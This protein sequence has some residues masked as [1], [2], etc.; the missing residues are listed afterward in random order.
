MKKTIFTTTLALLTTLLMCSIAWAQGVQKAPR[1]V[2]RT[3]YPLVTH[4]LP[5]ESPLVTL[6]ESFEGATFPPAGWTKLSPDGGAGW[7]RQLNN[8]APIPGWQGGRITVPPGGGNAVAFCTWNT[9]GAS[10][11]NQ[12]L[13][14]PQLTNVLA[15]DSLKFWMRY[16]PNSFSDTVEVRIS[17]TTPTVGAF[18]ILVATLPFRSPSADTN[19]NQYRYRLSDYVP[20]G[21]NIYVAFRERVSD[22]LNDGASISLDLVQVTSD[23][24]VTFRVNMKVQMLQGDFQPG[25]GDLVYVRG[26]FNGWNPVD[27]LSDGDG[28]SIYTKTIAMAEGSI[29]Y[30]YYK[31]QARGS[32]DWENDPD[33]QYTV[34]AGPQ[35]TPLVFFNRD[36]IYTPPAV[37]VPV[38]FQV[39][40]RVKMLEG[41]FNPGGGDIVRVAGNI[42]DWG[43]SLDTLRDADNDSIYTKTL[44]LA[45]GR[46]VLYKFLKTNNGSLGW[47]DGNNRIHIVPVGGGPIP[48]VYFDNDSLVSVPVSANILYHTDMR[49]FEQLG[50]F[51]P[52]VDS[53]QMRGSPNGWGGASMEP[54]PLAPGTYFLVVP[55]SGFSFD[56]IPYKY[57]MKLDSATA[58]TRFP[59]WADNMDGYNYEHP[60]VRGDGNRVFTVPA[61]GQQTT[62][63]HWY[64]DINPNGLLLNNTDSVTVTLRVN[65]GPAKRYITP[66]NPATDTVRVIWG[67]DAIWA[68]VQ[69]LYQGSFPNL[70]MSQAPGGGD[71]VYQVSFLV[72]GKTHYNIQYSYRYTQPGGFSVDEGGGLGGQNPQRSRFI[73][74]LA[75]NSFPR[76]YTAP[77]D[78]WQKN[79]PMPA[80]AAPFPILASVEPDLGPGIPEGYKLGQNYPNPFNPATKI[81]YTI[82]EKSKVTLF[83]YNLLGQKVSEIVNQEQPAGAYIATF[84][85]ANLPTGVYFYRLEAGKFM[86]SR[87]MLLLK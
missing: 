51:N 77:L 47:E 14:T 68:S 71:S 21:S 69:R 46:E 50:W 87:K 62:P 61:G 56:M 10:S 57:Y 41:S 25:S 65:M 72:R 35:S 58:V 22:N 8:T 63:L 84:E 28:D 43:N 60:A 5:L 6:S 1:Q 85:G 42:N 75:P 82:P 27:T 78:Q 70:I 29:A 37:N 52:A 40:M 79:P 20:A 2:D 36:S 19:W 16:W 24:A 54:D 44:S 83:V 73:Q 11:N 3:V 59:G 67:Q 13:V 64:G 30:K 53:M 55:Y 74:P 18:T 81:R 76:L 26:G 86:E 31:S 33:R 45:E 66:F 15:N 12:W 4:G 38:T 17:T 7:N 49:A 34:V 23:P 39:N 80:E 32:V 9:G 48:T